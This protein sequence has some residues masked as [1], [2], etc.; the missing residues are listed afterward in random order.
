MTF[1]ALSQLLSWVQLSQLRILSLV[2]SVTQSLTQTVSHLSQALDSPKRPTGPTC[3][4]LVWIVWKYWADDKQISWSYRP[5]ADL[6]NFFWPSKYFASIKLCQALSRQGAKITIPVVRCH[7]LLCS[8]AQYVNDLYWTHLAWAD[9]R[10]KVKRIA[11]SIVHF[12]QWNK[13]ISKM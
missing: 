4:I 13:L 10:I 5:L 3:R 1:R 2:P 9:F 6:H 8:S 12:D 11:H 7:Y